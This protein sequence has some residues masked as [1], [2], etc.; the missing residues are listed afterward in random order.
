M[1]YE[2]D[3][4]LLGNDDS[5]LR[6]NNNYTDMK[7]LRDD[8]NQGQLNESSIVPLHVDCD[9]S[10]SWNDTLCYIPYSMRPETYIVPILFAAI[11]LI[12]VLGNGTLV[13]IFLKVMEMSQLRGRKFVSVQP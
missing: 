11:F 6:K 13:F 7:G 12:G 8:E 9:D 10:I 4:L 5:N 3:A 1:D 2:K